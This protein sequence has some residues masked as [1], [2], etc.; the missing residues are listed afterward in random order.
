MRTFLIAIFLVKLSS[1]LAQDE[2]SWTISVDAKSIT[3]TA[4]MEEGWHIYSQYT[5]PN[6]GPVPTEFKIDKNNSIRPKGKVAEPSPV[7]AYDENFGGD[8][9]YFEEKVDFT[10]ELKVKSPGTV[11]GTITYMVCNDEKCLPPADV[12]FELEIKE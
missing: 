12:N 11:K 7:K 10:Q 6:V 4:V 9:M 2:V 3:F 8:V 5:D 1:L